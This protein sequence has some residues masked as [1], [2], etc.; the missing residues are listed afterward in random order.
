MDKIDVVVETICATGVILAPF[1]L[2]YKL[3]LCLIS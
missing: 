2:A 3:V 1:W